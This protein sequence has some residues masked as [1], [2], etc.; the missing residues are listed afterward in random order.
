MATLVGAAGRQAQSLRHPK[1]L[2]VLDVARAD[3]EI[4]IASEYMDGEDLAGLL[5]SAALSGVPIPPNVALAIARDTLETLSGVIEERARR[6]P[7]AQDGLRS[8][9]HGGLSPDGVFLATFGEALL[10]EV[11]VAGAACRHAWF[12][13]HMYALPYRAPEQLEGPRVADQRADV[14]SV[15]V[16][17]WEMLANRAL[18]GGADRLK[19]QVSHVSRDDTESLL[20]EVLTAPVPDLQTVQRPG[21]PVPA[22]VAALVARATTPL[23]L[24]FQTIA[25]MLG[26][27]KALPSTR[28]ASA[29]AI[30]ATVD[31]LARNQLESRRARIEHAT[32]ARI[33]ASVPPS[34]RDT[35]VPDPPSRPIAVLVR[36]GEPEP[37][38]FPPTEAPTATGSGVV[39]ARRPSGADHSARDLSPLPVEVVALEEVLEEVQDVEEPPAPVEL[40]VAS[41]PALAKNVWPE[42]E[43][44]GRSRMAPVAIGLGILLLCASG[45]LYW[46]FGRTKPLAAVPTVASVAGPEAS[47]ARGSASAAR[48]NDELPGPAAAVD[49]GL[50]EEPVP[51]AAKLENAESRRRARPDKQV[52]RPAEG[53]PAPAPTQKGFRPSGI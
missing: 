18:F 51:A 42:A 43:P 7:S 23:P 2:A 44:R 13:E 8:S 5:R 9:I 10:T 16:L 21:A 6:V 38:Y 1:L 20:R 3:D 12:A 35:D 46:T 11:G 26:A 14:Y 4:G 24:R 30:A 27:L 40:L 50:A 17:L 45:T 39:A 37:A 53:A 47:V 22:D 32:G 34:S 36:P 31:R 19:R 28:L 25:D 52:D 33:V 15:G 29:E 41:N 48:G 49:A